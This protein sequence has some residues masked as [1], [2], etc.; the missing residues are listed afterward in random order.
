MKKDFPSSGSGG[1]NG[2]CGYCS[3]L[4]KYDRPE[5]AVIGGTLRDVRAVILSQACSFDETTSSVHMHSFTTPF[6]GKELLP[7]G[8][9]D[10]A[11]T[12]D[13]V[14]ICGNMVSKELKPDEFRR[15]VDISAAFDTVLENLGILRGIGF[16]AK[17]G[18]DVLPLK[19]K[20]SG[21]VYKVD[22]DMFSLVFCP[23]DTDKDFLKHAMYLLNIAHFL[24]VDIKLGAAAP[25]SKDEQVCVKKLHFFIQV[26]SRMDWNAYF[27]SSE[28]GAAYES[29]VQAVLSGAGN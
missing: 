5:Y 26:A 10:S 13:Y 2:G 29:A 9:F 16:S 24:G 23:S 14:R 17:Y 19:V 1:F 25:A 27:T 28:M 3:H 7:C 4:V 20:H 21:D 8:T 12:R 6:V 22:C 11:D 18:A 15:L